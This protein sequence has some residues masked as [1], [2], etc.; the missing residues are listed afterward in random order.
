MTQGKA[1]AVILLLLMALLGAGCSSKSSSPPN[2]T[3]EV[4]AVSD[5]PTGW[6]VD[7]AV[8]AVGAPACLQPIASQPGA[9]LSAQVR[10]AAGTN[11]I[12]VVHEDLAW[13]PSG[14]AAALTNYDNL[15]GSCQNVTIT[16]RR[17]KLPGTVTSMSFPH[18]GDGS[19]AYQL[20]LTLRGV[21]IGLD[22]VTA[23]KGDTV[24]S[25]S[26][27]AI[28]TPDTSQVQQI[29]MTAISKIH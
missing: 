26:Y 19:A 10:F 2:L 25:L 4:L 5:L 14:G 16:Y 27:E 29:A 12:P 11:R 21:T 24:M 28:G 1:T 13:F 22:E 3:A 20:L 15:I 8:P 23:R 18:L 7:S 9:S 6:T 17:L